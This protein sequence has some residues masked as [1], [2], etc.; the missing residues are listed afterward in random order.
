MRT[1]QSINASETLEEL[2][3]T[4]RA[5]NYE[6]ICDYYVGLTFGEIADRFEYHALQVPYTL[7][8]LET[9]INFFRAAETRRLELEGSKK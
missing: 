2:Y 6:Y 1:F 9:K 5:Y 8:D 3:H 4:I 7:Y